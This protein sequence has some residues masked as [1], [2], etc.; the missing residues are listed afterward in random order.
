MLPMYLLT[1]KQHLAEVCAGHAML[2]SL[3]LCK[4]LRLQFKVETWLRKEEAN[5]GE[6]E[7]GQRK[8]RL[9]DSKVKGSRHHS[10]QSINPCNGSRLRG[11]GQG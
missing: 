5:E 10:D 8:A 11:D 3:S 6:G 9:R 2:H 1:V 4:M 7:M